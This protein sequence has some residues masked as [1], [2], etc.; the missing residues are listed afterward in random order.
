[1]AISRLQASLAAVTNEFTVAAAQMN[2]DFTLIK[3]EAPKEFQPLGE[4]LSAKRKHDAEQGTTHVTARRLGALFEGVC[5][6]TPN[7]VKAYGRRVSDISAVAAT[8][9]PPESAKSLFSAH[10]GI[11]GTSIWAAATSSPTALHVQLLACMLARVWSGPEATSLW[12]EIIKER[13]AEI[14]AKFESEDEIHFSTL[15]A[16]SQLDMPRTQ[17]ADWDDS[18]RSWLRTA[19]TIK[20]REQKQL[21]LILKNIDIAVNDDMQ[22]YSS[23]INAWKTALET[24]ENLVDGRPQ[25]VNNGSALLALSAWHLYPDIIVSSSSS[26]E[27]YMND[28]MIAAGGVLAL[29]LLKPD[30]IEGRG[31][32]W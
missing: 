27:V 20:Y 25:A 8:E 26:A 10:S 14:A 22:V 9:T 3:C 21:T 2:F 1:M 4:N 23:V 16:A 11:D 30:A 6:A 18:A 28:P 15:K 17:L 32:H 5:P 7:L 29:G 12:V 31:V 19:D 13:K 24:M